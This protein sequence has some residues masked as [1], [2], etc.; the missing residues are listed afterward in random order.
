MW[1]FFARRNISF[2]KT[3]Y[4]AEQK[5][6]D[7]VRARR[8]GLDGDRVMM[9]ALLGFKRAGVPVFFEASIVALPRICINGGRRGFLVGI[10]PRVLTD[11]LGAKPVACA[12]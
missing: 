3:L 7:V 4:A 11:V 9:E 8:R 12:L 2:K 1:R 10:E 6:A 5:R